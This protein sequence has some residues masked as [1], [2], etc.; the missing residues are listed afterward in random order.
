LIVEY[1]FF[2][3]WREVINIKNVEYCSAMKDSDSA[4]AKIVE[5]F[6]S[7]LQGALHDCPYEIGPIRIYNFTN[8]YM[9]EI[10]AL[11]KS[12][13]KISGHDWFFKGDSRIMFKVRTD[14]DP[15]VLDLLLAITTSF[16]NAESF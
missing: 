11:D 8:P 13:K 7:L 15:K 12:G 1:K 4:A 9:D 14:D 5:A 10:D 2:G 16:R 6:G 3:N